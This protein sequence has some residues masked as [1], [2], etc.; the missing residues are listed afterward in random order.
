[1]ALPYFEIIGG[2]RLKG[3]LR[4]NG[5]KNASLPIMAAALPV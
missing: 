1:M 3:T 2:R 4:I 5:A